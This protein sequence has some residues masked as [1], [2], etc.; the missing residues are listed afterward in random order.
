[1]KKTLLRSQAISLQ[2][3]NDGYHV[4]MNEKRFIAIKSKAKV[5]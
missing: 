5:S 1:M 2:T 4:V 3:M